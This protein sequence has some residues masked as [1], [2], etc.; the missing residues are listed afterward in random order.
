MRRSLFRKILSATAAVTLFGGLLAAYSASASPAAAS[1]EPTTDYSVPVMEKPSDTAISRPGL[2]SQSSQ[3]IVDSACTDTSPTEQICYELTK[4][5]RI[6]PAGGFS[7]QDAIPF[8]Y[9]C[10]QSGGNIVAA[11]R[12]EVCRVAGL[13]LTTRVTSNGVTTV[14][15]QLYSNVYDYS[16]S[17]A[18][19][20]NWQ[21]QIGVAPYDGWGDAARASVTGSMQA[22]GE[23]VT[24][25][26]GAFPTQSLAPTDAQIREGYAGVETTITLADTKGDAYCTTL[27]TL[28]LTVPG[29][30]ASTVQTSLS[31]TVCD[32]VI[33]SNGFRP[34]RV[35]CVIP[36]YPALVTYSQSR[37]PNLASHVSR[38][39]ASGLPGAT[40]AAPL[41]RTEDPDTVD[42]NRKLACG[43]APSIEGMSCDEYPLATTSQGL[44]SGGERRTF[45]GCG[46]NAPT[47]VTGPTGASAC[48]IPEGENQGQ[49]AVMAAFYYDNRVL[50]GDPY[51]V[52]IGS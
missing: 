4:P 20:P 42:T 9:W 1:P 13:T 35:G 5:K 36:W 32:N 29:Y 41:N 45:E 7:S 47:G 40:F 11:S 18:N 16:F 39:Q 25:G 24:D 12:T 10:S 6:E 34:A 50:E 52:G 27:W 3:T 43:D 19:F 30:P 46:I 38:A 2:R 17:S 21:H 8:P 51:R 22:L 28:T 49:G 37:Y 31:E 15:G 26:S 33:G 44:A 14:T 23:C 48:M